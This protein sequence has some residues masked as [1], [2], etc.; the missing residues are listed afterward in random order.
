MYPQDEKEEC[1]YFKDKS[2]FV[3]VVRCKDCDNKVDFNGR[4]MCK[5]NAK[6]LFGEWIGLIA[7]KDD[8]YCSYGKRKLREVG[9]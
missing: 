3:E 4:V 5:I 9:E 6:I 7:T 2:L 1:Q 8:H